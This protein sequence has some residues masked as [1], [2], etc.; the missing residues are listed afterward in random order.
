MKK[1]NFTNFLTK[2]LVKM[3]VLPLFLLVSLLW[4]QDAK[5]Q[6]VVLNE[7]QSATYLTQISQH[8]TNVEANLKQ[9]KQAG[10]VDGFANNQMLLSFYKTFAK[11]IRLQQSV[12]QHVLNNLAPA[13]LLPILV[14]RVG[15]IGTQNSGSLQQKQ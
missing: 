12:S 14:S 5:A 9:L 6:T 10:D 8:T 11:E 2:G 4:V 15:S 3:A 7:L 13:Q 1:T